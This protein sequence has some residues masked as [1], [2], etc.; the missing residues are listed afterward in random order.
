MNDLRLYAQVVIKTVIVVILHFRGRHGL[1]HKSVPQVQYQPRSQGLSGAGR[2]PGNEV[3]AVRLFS[4]TRP[5]KFLICGVVVVFAKAPYYVL[6]NS[7]KMEE[8]QL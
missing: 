2:D 3:G 8:R 7:I 4:L 5:I 1:I 6:I